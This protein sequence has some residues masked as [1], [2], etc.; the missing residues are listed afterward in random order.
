MFP[1]SLDPKRKYDSSPSGHRRTSSEDDCLMQFRQ[2]SNEARYNDARKP[3]DF[4][5]IGRAEV[6]AI[7]LKLLPPRHATDALRL[8]T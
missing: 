5:P 8:A 4:K 1:H 6:E 2:D 3:M 7:V